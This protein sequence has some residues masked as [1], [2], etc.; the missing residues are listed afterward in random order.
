MAEHRASAY[1]F[2]VA[3]VLGVLAAIPAAVQSIGVCY[4]VNG[5]GLPSASDVVELYKSNGIA[6]MRVYTVNDDTLQA[7]SGSN[8][9]LI[10][11]TGNTQ[12]N[13]LASSASNADS[14]VKANVQSHQ[15]LTIKY[16]AVGNEVPGQGGNPRDILPA[17]KNIRNALV[18]AGL[19]G[20]K[21]STAV[22][23]DTVTQ[24]F[25]PSK[26]IFNASASHMPPIAQ[27]LAS[28]GAPL[29]ANIYPYFSY[30]GDT[31]HITL[32]YALFSST[33]TVVTDDNGNQ[34]QNLF[35]AL[36]D[37]MYS[38]LESAR[39]GTV[40]I[41][42][43]ESGWPSAGD[44][45]VATMDNAQMYNQNLINHVEK[46]TPKRPGNIETYIFA[47][48]NENNKKGE[49]TEKHFGLFNP[50]QSPAYPIIFA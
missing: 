7:L 32:D 41:V 8:L 5:D 16:I 37:T 33:T 3:M 27:Y 28:T 1:M 38:A 39:A 26:G 23:S 48:F 36:V 15:G 10:L 21:V 35:D 46:G 6:G 43:S 17:M 44:G 30:K 19:G 25:P 12:L 9:G 11:D 45:T 40:P 4:G 14:W 47:M 22:N 2:A 13:A 34:Y 42:V 31:S 49:E 29:L 20:I 18:R 50:D 24:G